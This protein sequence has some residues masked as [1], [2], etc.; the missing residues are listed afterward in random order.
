MTAAGIGAS[1]EALFLGVQ[2]RDPAAWRDFVGR[3][4]PLVLAL[5]R[6]V[7][8]TAGEED[9]VVQLT[10]ERLLQHAAQINTPR[11]VPAWVLQVAR[12]E[13]WAV[14]RRR[15][16]GQHIE[17]A[18]G[19]ERAHAAEVGADVELQRLERIQLVRDAVDH[20]SER[21]AG[22][23]R[24]LFLDAEEPDYIAISARLGMP[25]GSIGPSRQRC[26]AK[27]AAELERR[28]VSASDLEDSCIAE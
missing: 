21:C 2:R 13:A 6:R 12:R 9:E 3:F 15:R 5:V 14:V 7:G 11:A 10:W 1:D 17:L 18:A 20:L 22:L 8:C 24:V 16:E 4:G 27:L 28:G 23:L 19:A 26:L 25:I